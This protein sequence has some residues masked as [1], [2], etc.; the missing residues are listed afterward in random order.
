MLLIKQIYVFI[1]MGI[2]IYFSSILGFEVIQLK[3]L[4]LKVVIA[5]KE[6]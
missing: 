1:I 2:I 4:Y 6:K 3:K 5:T